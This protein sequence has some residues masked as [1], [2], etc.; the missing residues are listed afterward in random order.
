MTQAPL[1]EMP[2]AA[3]AE[4]VEPYKADP[5][6]C[7]VAAAL[8]AAFPTFERGKDYPFCTA[9]E[10][11]THNLIFHLLKFTGPCHL[12]AATWSV[13]EKA[14]VLLKYALERKQILSVRFLV[15]WRVR[16]RTPAFMALSKQGFGVVR[17]SNCHAKAFVLHNDDWSVSSV[18]SAN[19]TNN[20]RIEAGHISTN[21]AVSAFHIRW[22]NA[23]IERQEPFG[24]DLNNQ[25]KSDTR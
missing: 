21:P 20:P 17:V 2:S 24:M 8:E 7:K 3:G 15:D 18:G 10:W 6:L 22:I 23:E 13:S 1:F 12:V 4:S 14:T 5:K 19:F 25:G 9:S 16:V 11:S